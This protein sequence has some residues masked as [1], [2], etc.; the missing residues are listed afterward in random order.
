MGNNIA[1]I[2]VVKIFPSS[3]SLPFCRYACIM[4]I[5]AVLPVFLTVL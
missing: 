3:L 4:L 1:I 5:V 2:F